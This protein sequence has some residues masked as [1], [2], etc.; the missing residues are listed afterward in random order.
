[1]N[2]NV[3]AHELGHAIVGYLMDK[4]F[5]PT[6]IEL[7]S[8]DHKV[9]AACIF[10]SNRMEKPKLSGTK[11]VSDLGGLI[12]EMIWEGSWRV[13]G[14]S[15]DL[16]SIAGS[17]NNK[18]AVEIDNWMWMENGPKSYHGLMANMSRSKR[19]KIYVDESFT[20]YKLPNVWKVYKKVLKNINSE[21]FR[22]IV[23][24]IYK[25]KLNKI[26]YKRLHGYIQRI[27]K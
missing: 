20:Q 9:K 13:W 3:I 24:E 7:Y 23:N 5:W 26:L 17:G 12:G 4:D 8:N 14:A 6:N 21:E 2:K 16:D 25:E 27:V 1:M 11:Y 19:K 18:I 22:N 15:Y 10:E